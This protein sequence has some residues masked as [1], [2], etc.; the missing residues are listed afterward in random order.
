MKYYKHKEKAGLYEAMTL[1]EGLVMISAQGGGFA[2]TLTED[3]LADEFVEVDPVFEYQY[4]TVTADFLASNVVVPC[5]SNGKRWNGFGMPT[6]TLEAGKSMLEMMPDLTYDEVRDAFV[7][8]PR[9]GEEEVYE[10]I[11]ILVAREAIKVY[12]IGTGG[13]TWD[14]VSL[15]SQTTT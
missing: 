15:P 6:F 5:Y 3:Q 1:P 13:W 8:R 7:W 11:A 12:P 2:R 9:D 14:A 10:P 4:G